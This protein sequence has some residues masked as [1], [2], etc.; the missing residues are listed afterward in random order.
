MKP[1]RDA[2][3]QSLEVQ[4]GTVSEN[5]YDGE[6]IGLTHCVDTIYKGQRSGSYLFVKGKPNITIGAQ[7]HSK[8]LIIDAADRTC[9]GVTAIDPSGNE[10]SFYATREVIL[11]QESSKAR[12]SQC[13][14]ASA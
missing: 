6:M 14:A 5:I 4:G 1:F 3:D 13:S 7:L 11:S 12:S 9:K 2:L 8:R 10:L